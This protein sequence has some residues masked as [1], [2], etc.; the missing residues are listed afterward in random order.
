M[1]RAAFADRAK[2]YAD[3]DFVNVPVEQ[4]ISKEYAAQRRT[5]I[6]MSHAAESVTQ[7]SGCTRVVIQH[8]TFPCQPFLV[9]WVTDCVKRVEQCPFFPTSITHAIALKDTPL[10][11]LDVVCLSLLTVGVGVTFID[12]Y[13]PLVVV[14][15]CWMR[16]R[17]RLTLGRRQ[18]RTHRSRATPSISLRPTVTGTW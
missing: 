8:W 11:E 17:G 7:S 16:A 1:C 4:L 13:W 10:C 15:I 9:L 12:R 18:S 14:D 6:N 2:Y 5:L 3:P